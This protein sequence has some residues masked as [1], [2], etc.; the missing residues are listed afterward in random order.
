MLI[1][2]GTCAPVVLAQGESLPMPRPAS[3]GQAE[4]PVASPT[5]PSRGAELAEQRGERGMGKGRYDALCHRV[6]LRYL[7]LSRYD[8]SKDGTIDD[9]EFE[10]LKLD[11]RVAHRNA[12]E[13]FVRR[14]DEGGKGKL[15]HAEVE[16]MQKEAGARPRV[17]RQGQGQGRGAPTRVRNPLALLLLR[18]VILERYDANKNGKLDPE[19]LSDMRL[20]AEKLYA[21]FRRE[22]IEKYDVD[23]DGSLSQLEVAEAVVLLAKS[24]VFVKDMSGKKIEPAEGGDATAGKNAADMD[25]AV[26]ALL[27]DELERHIMESIPSVNTLD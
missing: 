8:T 13:E 16:K 5:S 21:E 12:R 18:D 3:T 26:E 7:I 2:L 17:Q 10:K 20:E 4:S 6:L 1:A 23:K 25:R 24:P 22:L 27:D 15:T 14:F 9:A 19:E 11:S